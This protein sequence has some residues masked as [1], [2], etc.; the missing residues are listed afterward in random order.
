MLALSYNNLVNW[1]ITIDDRYINYYFI[2]NKE[3]KRVETRKI[4]S[5]NEEA[6][7]NIDAFYK[8]IEKFISSLVIIQ[9]SFS[10][11]FLNFII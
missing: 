9:T 7:L 10:R 8:I 3:K 1:H 2:L 5:G 6:T 11:F 4:E